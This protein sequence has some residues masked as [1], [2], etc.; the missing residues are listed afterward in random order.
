MHDSKRALKI[1]KPAEKL[2]ISFALLVKPS[3]EKRMAILDENEKL[4]KLRDWLLPMLM[5]GQV[6]VK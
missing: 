3:F 1:I 5:S 2:L 6:T 4:E